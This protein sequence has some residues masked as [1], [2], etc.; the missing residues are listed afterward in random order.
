[1]GAYGRSLGLGPRSYGRVEPLCLWTSSPIGLSSSLIKLEK[2]LNIVIITL[3]LI[4]IKNIEY[5]NL[6]KYIKY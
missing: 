2:L 4:I 6:I 1:M 3:I 5:I